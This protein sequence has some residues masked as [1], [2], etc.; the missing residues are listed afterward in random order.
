[1]SLED[2][3][4]AARRFERARFL[5]FV[6]DGAVLGFVR[7]DHIPYL[8]AYRG[9]LAIGEDSISLCPEIGTFEARTAAMASVA[10][11]LATRGLLSKW[12][13]ESYDIAADGAA[14]AFALERSAVRFFGF[15][16]KAVHLNGLVRTG[17]GIDMWIGRRSADKAIDPGMLDNMV[18]G[19]IASGSCVEAT[20]VKEAAEEAGIP[21]ALARQ[22]VPAGALRV[23]REVAEGLHLET[24]HAYDLFLAAEFVPINQDGEV[25][26]FRRASLEAVAGELAGDA[27]YT[28][29]AA[30]VALDCL[31][32]RLH[33]FKC[34]LSSRD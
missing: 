2:R 26:E 33:G 13:D 28:V 27:P 17:A 32:R 9:I 25:A 4:R 24:I 16:A 19:G 6:A 3:V 22:A 11:S 12:R 18:G 31:A 10:A 14:R 30:L 23:A 1:M 21:S 7:R 29:D 5:S 8:K 34:A 20:L 15:A